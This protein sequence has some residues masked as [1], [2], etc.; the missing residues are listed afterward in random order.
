MTRRHLTLPIVL[1]VVMIVLI[2]A[3]TIGWVL[4]T[5]PP[6]AADP[7]RSP[8]YI[9]L[10]TVGCSLLV[11]VLVGVVFYLVLSI[12]AV[13][14]TRRQSNFIDSVT[15][16]LKSPIASLKL[17]LQT[18]DR[19]PVP[20]EEQAS[21]HKY[22]MEDVERLDSLIN[23][24]LD[25]ARLERG[26][27]PSGVERIDL[28][29]VI[30]RSAE[31]VAI[32]HGAPAEAIALDLAPCYVMGQAVDVEL[33]FRNLIDNALKYGGDGPRVDVS[34]HVEG[35]MAV[36][37]IADH[38][39]GVPRQLRRKIFGRFVRL[40]MELERK[41]AGTGLGLY[42]VRTA[43]RRLKGKIHVSSRDKDPGAVFEVKLPCVVNGTPEPTSQQEA[44]PVG[45]ALANEVRS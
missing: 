13:N 23:D 41:K 24:L 10:L 44:E 19:N 18:L 30:R 36:T 21:F 9:T 2:V 32:R 11:L 25:V 20:P 39:R 37:R 15:H 12:K 7:A 42:L 16:E 34:L 43:V 33:I 17:I 14:L 29:E 27:K 8:L 4:L 3:L 31:T 6:I 5:A 38:G 35:N 1:G 26:E 22:M 28:A 45:E 40:G